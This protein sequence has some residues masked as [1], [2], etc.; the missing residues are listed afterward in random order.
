MVEVEIIALKGTM[1]V[2]NTGT[3]NFQVNAST[4]RRPLDI[5]DLEVV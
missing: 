1:V 2:I 5:V 3:S 4:L